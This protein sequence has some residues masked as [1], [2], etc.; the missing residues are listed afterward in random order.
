[1]LVG[2]GTKLSEWFMHQPKQYAATLKLGATTDT[3]DPESPEQPG[4]DPAGIT[5]D[6]LRATAGRFC[7]QLQQRP[8]VYSAMKIGGRRA[9][10]LA[11]RGQPVEPEARAVRIDRLEVESLSGDLAGFT[12]DCGRGT[13]IRSLARDL[14]AAVG[15]TGYLVKLRRTRVGPLVASAAV[16]PD[17]LAREGVLAHLRPLD[18]FQS[19]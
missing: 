6:A 10:D 13:Y 1:V 19:V 7:G 15:T 8:P 9:Y 3:L 5:L 11:R 2:R 17:M 12:V 18:G 14:A 16:T 4:P